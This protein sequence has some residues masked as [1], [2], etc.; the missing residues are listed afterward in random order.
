VIKALIFVAMFEVVIE[1]VVMAVIKNASNYFLVVM[2]N[3]SQDS[4]NYV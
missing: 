2:P 4:R 1:V 3:L